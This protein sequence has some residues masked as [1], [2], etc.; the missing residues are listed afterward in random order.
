[1]Q[2]WSHQEIKGARISNT[3]RRNNMASV[4]AKLAEKPG[5]SFSAAVGPAKRQAFHR[6]CTAAET[7]TSD[8]FLE[9]HYEQTRFR[10][11]QETRGGLVLLVQ[12]TTMFNFSG[13]K[14]V[15]DLGYCN[16]KGERCL[17]GHS[18]L[19]LNLEG[20]PLGLAHLELWA[21]DEAQVG[22]TK[23][24]RKN[25]IT[26][27]ESYRWISALHSV[28][29]Q[30]PA[31]QPV[32]FIQDREADI[33]AF[34]EA[35]TRAMSYV[36]IRSGQSRKVEVDVAG[37]GEARTGLLHDIAFAAP[38]LGQMTV[39]IP[40]APNRTSSDINFSV[41]AVRV[42]IMPP[43]NG[44][45]S[46]RKPVTA[47][48]V[49]TSEINPPEGERAIEWILVTTFPTETYKQACEL[50]GYYAKR[51]TI[52]RL[53]YT[54]KS[55]GC[56]AER[57]QMDDAHSIKLALACYYITAWRLLYISHIS[58]TRPDAPVG[59]ILDDMEIQVLTAIEKRQIKTC[60]DAV[61]AIAKLGGYEPYRNGPPPGVKRLWIGLRRLE[62]MAAG[63][64]LARQ[65]LPYDT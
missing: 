14:K 17:F 34:L 64:S 47:W 3:R 54:I 42:R 9:G 23:D 33:F 41:Q 27:K 43:Q 60:A 52:E 44:K 11:D 59:S 61:V 22:K 7:V 58:R 50:V 55:G 29:A 48:V 16:V 38:V 30:L 63:W 56:N 25:D 40:R 36:L 49:R 21:R 8:D 2:I 46:S 10:I 57:L 39:N 12:D 4:L 5:T 37:E 65:N 24:R 1:M 26:Q 15:P 31:G 6:L 51:W 32:L 19:A 28:E 18:M 13:L 45:N 20:L 53:H 62:D 35:P